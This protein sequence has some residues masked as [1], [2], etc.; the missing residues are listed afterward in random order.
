MTLVLFALLVVLFALEFTGQR[1]LRVAAVV[2]VGGLAASVVVDLQTRVRL[3]HSDQM[4]TAEFLKE[5]DPQT[6]EVAA[7]ASQKYV[8]ALRQASAEDPFR[9]GFGIYLARERSSA[10]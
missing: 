9:P 4:Q 1:L 3:C 6:C 10:P 7:R 5:M 2:V 8:R